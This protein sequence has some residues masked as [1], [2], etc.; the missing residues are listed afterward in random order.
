MQLVLMQHSNSVSHC[1]LARWKRAHWKWKKPNWFS[2]SHR[3]NILVL[4]L[5]W[6]SKNFDWNACSLSS[7]QW[8]EAL[9]IG[10]VDSKLIM[11]SL[12][13]L[14]R[15]PWLICL[16]IWYRRNFVYNKSRK[17]H[18]KIFVRHSAISF[19]LRILWCDLLLSGIYASENIFMLSA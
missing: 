4:F 18:I 14:Q 16:S 3:I 6:T 10:K 15:L 1:G 5:F 8:L 9:R 11:S 2:K 12:L 19:S 17:N 7:T 13:S